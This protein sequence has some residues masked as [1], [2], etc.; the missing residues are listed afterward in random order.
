M[1]AWHKRFLLLPRHRINNKTHN[2]VAILCQ[3][4]EMKLDVGLF[5]VRGADVVVLVAVV[6]EHLRIRLQSFALFVTARAGACD[7]SAPF[8]GVGCT[9]T[10]S[11]TAEGDGCGDWTRG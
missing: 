8:D 3:V 9:G 11:Y 1:Q 5:V 4:R 7:L 2:L 10:L 6:A